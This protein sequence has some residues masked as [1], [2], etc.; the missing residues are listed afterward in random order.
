MQPWK[1]KLDADK[2]VFYLFANSSRLTTE[3]D[4]FARQT[5]VTQDTFLQYVKVAGEKLGYKV[6]TK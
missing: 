3:V 6:V 4:Y 1:I 2:Y 5:M